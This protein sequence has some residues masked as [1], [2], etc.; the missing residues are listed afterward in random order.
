MHTK[1]Q[2]GVIQGLSPEQAQTVAEF[3][4]LT[5]PL[6]AWIREHHD[7]HTE[8]TVSWDHAYIKHDGLSVPFPY[9]EK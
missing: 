9:L 5:A 3:E 1:P 8:V 4:A 7:P 6:V 2:A